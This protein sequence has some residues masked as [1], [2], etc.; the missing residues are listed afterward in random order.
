MV[1]AI[2]FNLSLNIMIWLIFIVIASVW[3]YRKA[4]KP[5]YY[6]TERGIAHVKPWPIFGNYGPIVIGW[7]SM[8]DQL[9]IWYNQFSTERYFGINQFSTPTLIILDLELIKKVMV[10]DHEYFIDHNQI[11][12][13]EVEPLIARNLF[14]LKG[15]RWRDMRATL[16]PSFTT[17]KIKTMF[18]LISECAAEFA[19]YFIKQN[20]KSSEVELKDIFTRYTNDVI[21]TTAYGLRFNSLE[22]KNN[23]FYLMG[24][25]I[26][27]FGIP[28][29]LIM[30][31]GATYP[32]VAKFLKLTAISKSVSDF[33]T[34]IIQETIRKREK[35]NLVRPDMIQLLME[36][37][38]EHNASVTLT[39]E[40]I[41]AQALIFFFGGFETSASQMTFIGYELALNE[42]I[43]KRL[44][45]EIDRTLGDCN[46]T[47]TYEALNKME[48]MDMV[49]SETLRKWPVAFMVD[50]L[51]V[52]D[53]TIKPIHSWEKSLIIEKGTVIHIP[54]MGL[55]RNPQYFSNPDK[56]D[57]ERFNSNNKHEIESTTYLPFGSGP[58]SC[59]ASRFALIE[60]KLL[61]FH[62][63]AKF[64]LVKIDKTV[65]PMKVGK[66]LFNIGPADD[67][68][69][70][71]RRRKF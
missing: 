26:T 19:E 41:N 56:F 9:L 51:C 71:I 34:T 10:K 39:D 31:F 44:Q 33:F 3:F 67:V 16:S 59:I 63:L 20:K 29:M 6:W 27:T 17:S 18:P 40:D 60:T 68:W 7:I 46:G 50:R 1:I 23:K 35:E 36:A 32:K 55:H 12:A 66:Q 61:M 21:A 69:L 43:Q 22:D 58:R 52:K 53:Y 70:E 65:Y 37:R 4:I 45:K 38:K 57:P 14:N 13:E 24:R 48:Y 62:L 49:I 54:I 15:Q 42:D 30:K 2:C 11:A 64:D 5:M 47:I 25:K 28:D 8:Y